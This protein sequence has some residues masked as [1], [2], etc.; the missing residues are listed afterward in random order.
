MSSFCIRFPFPYE[1]GLVAFQK[2]ETEFPRTPNEVNR[3]SVSLEGQTSFH[4]VNRKLVSALKGQL[5]QV[6]GAELADL[7]VVALCLC[8]GLWVPGRCSAIAGVGARELREGQQIRAVHT[9]PVAPLER[10]TGA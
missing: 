5:N 9:G 2:L 8:L 1:N 10:R 3:K 7:A 4:K 6:F